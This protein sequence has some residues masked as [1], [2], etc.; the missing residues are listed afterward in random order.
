[1]SVDDLVYKLFNPES[2]EFKINNVVY[3]KQSDIPENMLNRNVKYWE[4]K[5]H[6]VFGNLLCINIET[7]DYVN[8]LIA[9]KVML[10]GFGMA[11]VKLMMKSGVPLSKI[12]EMVLTIDSVISVFTKFRYTKDQAYHVVYEMYTNELLEELNDFILGKE[13]KQED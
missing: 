12:T 2:C 7:W 4:V 6:T 11:Q 5:N 8:A 13:I 1:M 9:N 3:D 10:A